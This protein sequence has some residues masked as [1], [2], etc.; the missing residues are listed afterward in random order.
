VIRAAGWH[1]REWHRE[2]CCHRTGSIR[3]P[4]RVSQLQFASTVELHVFLQGER[5]R[6]GQDH[7]GVVS[8][9][10]M[11]RRWAGWSEG[12]SVE[13]GGILKR[14]CCLTGVLIIEVGRGELQV[15]V[16]FG[17][18]TQCQAVA[19]THTYINKPTFMHAY[20][21]LLLRCTITD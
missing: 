6:H 8:W 18:Q 5:S 2:V 10:R 11:V 4:V 12:M 21:T 19:L 17:F 16:V 3:I 15:V 13:L 1:R 20:P 7:I 9:G 14:V